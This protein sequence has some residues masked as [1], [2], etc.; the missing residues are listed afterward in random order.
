MENLAGRWFIDGIDLF[1]TFGLFIEE[2]SADFLKFPPKKSSIEHDWQDSDGRDVDLS[3][4]FFD[5]R[6]GTLNIAIISTDMADFFDKQMAFI[7]QMK[8]PG[9]RRFTLKSHGERSY[10]IY[11]KECN[12]FKPV[13]ALTGED[14][15]YFAHRFSMVVVEP[16]PVIDAQHLFII[17]HDDNYLIA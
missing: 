10:Y 3:R 8:Q 15:G 13:K 2:G 17:D 1:G 5:Q 7:A 14:T 4:I 11:Y 6:E 12:N 16:E 9:T